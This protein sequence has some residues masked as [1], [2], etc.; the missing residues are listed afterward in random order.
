MMEEWN[1]GIMDLGRA[2]EM[3]RWGDGEEGTWMQ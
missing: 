2:G 3:G 1:N